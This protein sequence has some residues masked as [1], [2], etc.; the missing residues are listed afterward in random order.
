[1]DVASKVNVLSAISEDTQPAAAGKRRVRKKR[2]WKRKRK[3]KR[4]LS[5]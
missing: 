3:W 4:K 2:H 1:M 5:K